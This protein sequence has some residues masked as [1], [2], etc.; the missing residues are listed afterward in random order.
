[1]HPDVNF[2]MTSFHCRI[3][4]LV[5]FK[6]LDPFNKGINVITKCMCVGVK[7]EQ[8]VSFADK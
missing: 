4:A 3:V 6:R 2:E 7:G 1:M 5:A 8:A